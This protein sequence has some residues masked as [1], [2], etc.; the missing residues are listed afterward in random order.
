M[1][2]MAPGHE[3]DKLYERIQKKRTQ[4]LK[5]TLSNFLFIRVP[6]FDP[7]RQR[8]DRHFAWSEDGVEIVGLTACGR[9]TVAAL[10]LNSDLA[11]TVR[12]NWLRAGW[13]PPGR[14]HSGHRP[15]SGDAR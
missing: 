10:R 5:S 4:E 11:V 13:H 2:A 7:R 8:W 12:R 1:L 14:G 3:D 6:L 15:A 9:A